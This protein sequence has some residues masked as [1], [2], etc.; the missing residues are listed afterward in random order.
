MVQADTVTG[1]AVM[2][3]VTQELMLCP[4]ALVHTVGLFLALGKSSHVDS[5]IQCVFLCTLFGHPLNNFFFQ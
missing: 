2:T 5:N 3:Q 1:P 4:L